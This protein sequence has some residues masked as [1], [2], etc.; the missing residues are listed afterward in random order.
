MVFSFH[1]DHTI[2]D[3]TVIKKK[4]ILIIIDALLVAMNR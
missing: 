1:I 3:I 2:I 4:I